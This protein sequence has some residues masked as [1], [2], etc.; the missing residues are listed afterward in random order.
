[1]TMRKVRKAVFPVAGLG[2]RFLPVTKAS[3][4]E[5]LPI[6]DKPLIQFAVE[7]AAAAGITEMIFV[8]GR[9]KR[10]IEDH[11]DKAHELEAELLTRDKQELLKAVQSVSPK[12][13]HFIFIRQPQALGLGHAVWC[14]KSVVGPEPF[15]VLLADDLLDSRSGVIAQL[16]RA[17]E[18]AHCSIL[19][20]IRVPLEEVSCY[21]I[22]ESNQSVGQSLWRVQGVEEKP[23]PEK[24]K[25]TLA[26][27]GRYI[28][29]PRI[30]ECLDGLSPGKSGEIQLTDGIERLLRC[31][32]VLAYLIE[33]LRH[34]CGS[35][36][37]YMKAVV[38]YGLRHAE[39]GGGFRAF[40]NSV[41]GQE[42]D[43]DVR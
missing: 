5:M 26:V 18:E 13:T 35:K 30:F 8:T 2:S 11:F 17:Y 43:C 21:G 9:N 25:S 36:L 34:D 3:P 6:V 1:M 15:A 27:I 33:A 24:A 41:I 40:L 7:E 14:A 16:I 12:S 32:S 23:L 19:G 4:K 29:T 42:I 31:E 20:I 22:I 39:V 28:L 10:A 38:E 37:G